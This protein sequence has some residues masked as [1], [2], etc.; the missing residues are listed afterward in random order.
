MKTLSLVMQKYFGLM[1][2]SVLLG[3]VLF[4][5]APGSMRSVQAKPLLATRTFTIKNNCGYT[6]YPGIY[7]AST[8][9]NG[10]WSMAAGAQVSSAGPDG[11]IGR[12]WRRTGCNGASPAVCTTGS[13][14][15]S[16]LQCAGTTGFPNTSLFEWNINAGGTDWYDVS[17]VDAVDNPIGV[18]VSNSGCVSP[19]TCSNS[20]LTNCPADLRSGSVCLSP[21]TKYNTDQYCCRGAYG[22]AATCV[23]ANWAASA[24]TYVNNVHTYCP[25]EYAY[26]YDEN[27]G[28]A[29]QTCATGASYTITFCPAGGSGSTGWTNCA[30]ENGTCSFS[31][32]MAV[33]YGAN[34]S[35]YYRTATSNI[36]CNNA[37]FGDPIVGTVKHCDY[38]PQPPNNGWTQCAGENGTCSFSGTMGVAYG[39]NG[40]FFYR[41]ATGSIACNNAT[42]GDPIFGTAKACYYK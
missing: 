27:S 14:G 1:L 19:N 8:Y 34:S 25:R 2:L 28:G 29:L 17:Y 32:T 13:C 39:A 31:G 10:G 35:Y 23:V 30:S 7:P 41:P 42:F 21:C 11:N 6:I 38:S 12:L 36:A 33:R 3:I 4:L 37:T 16:G 18:Q 24:Q 40:A 20:V 22:T 26:A 5:A 9:S 15:G